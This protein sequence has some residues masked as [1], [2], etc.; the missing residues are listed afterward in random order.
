MGANG[1]FVFGS[2]PDGAGVGPRTAGCWQDAVAD[3]W[4]CVTWEVCDLEIDT[5]VLLFKTVRKIPLKKD[6]YQL[7]VILVH[8]AHNAMRT[9]ETFCDPGCILVWDLLYFFYYAKIYLT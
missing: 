5:F 8:K 7:S 9:R 4:V 2:G 6:V 1:C 3:L